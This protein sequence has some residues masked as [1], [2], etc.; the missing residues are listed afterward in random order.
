MVAGTGPD[1]QDNGIYARLFDSNGVAL[2][3]DFIVNDIQ[4]LDQR[5]GALPRAMLRRDAERRV[6]HVGDGP[7]VSSAQ[8]GADCR[9]IDASVPAGGT[10]ARVPA[11][12]RAQ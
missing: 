8:R 5:P 2:G 3:D 12:G 1:E 9:R 11:S 7:V 6:A 4:D 10:G